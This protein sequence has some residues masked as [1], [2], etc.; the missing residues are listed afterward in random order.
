MIQGSVDE[1]LHARVNV[2]ILSADLPG[3]TIDAVIDTGFTGFLTLSANQ[4]SQLGLKELGAREARL[5]DGQFAIFRTF[6][7]TVNWHNKARPVVVLQ[8]D[9]AALVGMELLRGQR[10]TVDVLPGGTVSIKKSARRR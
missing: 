10:L 6:L 1:R 4:I 8:S 5:G 7:A 9:A 2:E 3:T